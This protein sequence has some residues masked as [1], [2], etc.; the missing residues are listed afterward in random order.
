MTADDLAH[1]IIK[2]T[3]AMVFFMSDTLVFVTI[4]ATSHERHGMSNHQPLESFVNSLLG[5]IAKKLVPCEGNPPVNGGFLS[6]RT[7]DAKNVMTSWLSAWKNFYCLHVV[8]WY[9]MDNIFAFSCNKVSMIGLNKYLLRHRAGPL[10]SAWSIIP[11]SC[12]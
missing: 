7:S 6:Q 12:R 10:T 1:I 4:T 2:S 11:G 8:T 9:N 3:A 5:I